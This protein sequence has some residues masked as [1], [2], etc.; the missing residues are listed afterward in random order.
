VRQR[1]RGIHL[2]PQ[3]LAIGPELRHPSLHFVNRR[4]FKEILRHRP[5]P[6]IASGCSTERQ[7][8]FWHQIVPASFDLTLQAPGDSERSHQGTPLYL[9]VDRG[10]AK[11]TH[12]GGGP[13]QPLAKLSSRL[14]VAVNP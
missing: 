8:E 1:L 13:V 10:T 14:F 12:S 2:A 5:V 4:R 6:I 3:P 11:S 7:I 9:F